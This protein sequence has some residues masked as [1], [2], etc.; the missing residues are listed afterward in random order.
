MQAV[1]LAGGLAQRMRPL[2]EATPKFLL[3]VAGRPFAAWQLEQ[4]ARAGL[5]DVVLSIGHLGDRIRSFVGDGSAF[6]VSVRYAEDGAT[7]LRTGGALVRARELGLLRE[8]FLVTYGDSFLPFDH[9]AP[10][11]ALCD[12]PELVGVM[13]VYRNDGRWDASNVA[14]SE[15]GARVS[16]Y[17]KGTADPALDHIDYGATALRASAL[18]GFASGRA[19]GLDELQHDL[20]ARGVLGASLARERFYE[21]GSPQGLADL[22]AH[23]AA[24]IAARPRGA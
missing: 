22:E 4:L 12:A 11:R 18:D 16:R 23:L 20:A 7:L 15:D 17:E 5:S 1:V 8:T 21:I 13:A 9:A 19:F 6:G 24:E 10:L 2:T 14:L 3:P